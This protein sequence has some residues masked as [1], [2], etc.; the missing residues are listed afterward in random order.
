MRRILVS[1]S[2]IALALFIFAPATTAVGD[3]GTGVFWLT[4]GSNGTGEARNFNIGPNHTEN[5][6][7][8]TYNS[9]CS[10]ACD[11]IS[12]TAS[13]VIFSCGSLGTPID[14]NDAINLYDIYPNV[15]AHVLINPNYPG[16]CSNGRII[17]NLSSVGFDNKASGMITDEC[18]PC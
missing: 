10:G 3:N 16:S 4:S 15:G 1:V 11:I 6:T 7:A 9:N 5:L 12:N 2:L 13:S 17:V 14:Q 18:D 8:L